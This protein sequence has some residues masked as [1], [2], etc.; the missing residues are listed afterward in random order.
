MDIE[1]ST[2][3]VALEMAVKY[4]T[5]EMDQ[6]NCHIKPQKM[7]LITDSQSYISIVTQLSGT[8]SITKQTG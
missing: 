8:D 4:V 1:F 7:W 6:H 3:L 2:I 5:Q